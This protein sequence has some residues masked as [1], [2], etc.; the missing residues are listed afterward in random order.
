MN[1]KK[2]KIRIESNRNLKYNIMDL[3]SPLYYY[4]N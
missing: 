2:F 3:I 1:L 4:N